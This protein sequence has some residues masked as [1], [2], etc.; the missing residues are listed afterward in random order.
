MEIEE[1]GMD[2]NILGSLSLPITWETS[3]L[4]GGLEA[5][6]PNQNGFPECDEAEQPVCLLLLQ[7]ERNSAGLFQQLIWPTLKS[8]GNER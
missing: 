4:K 3:S 8:L 2:T 1:T 5:T 6:A 7:N